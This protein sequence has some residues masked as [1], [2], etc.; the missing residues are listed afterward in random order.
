MMARL[1]QKY[2]HN[3]LDSLEATFTLHSDI[4]IE[5]RIFKKTSAHKDIFQIYKTFF[6]IPAYCEK[7]NFLIL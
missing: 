6:W 7:I 1:Y 5:F 4:P 2:H 3:Y